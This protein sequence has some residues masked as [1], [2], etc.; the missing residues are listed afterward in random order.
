MNVTELTEQAA[1]GAG[2]RLRWLNGGLGYVPSIDGASA[3]TPL[4]DDGQCARLEVA[5][6][7]SVD[8]TEFGVL[9]ERVDGIACFEAF[10][11]HSGDRDKARRMASVR[12]AAEIGKAGAK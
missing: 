9:S 12:A 4:T 5:C 11:K 7:L 3:W 8:V 10:S 1:R 2:Y 6:R